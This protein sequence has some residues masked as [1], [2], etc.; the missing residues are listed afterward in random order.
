MTATNASARAGEAEL[1]EV[2]ERMGG[3]CGALFLFAERFPPSARQAPAKRECRAAQLARAALSES[4][5]AAHTITPRRL[6]ATALSSRA[7]AA[8]A[9]DK[10]SRPPTKAPKR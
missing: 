1:L 10:K 8:A 3:S 4:N 7:V 6:C 2:S 5:V 9:P